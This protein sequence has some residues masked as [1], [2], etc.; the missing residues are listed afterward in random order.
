M[1]AVGTPAAERTPGGLGGVRHGPSP[2]LEVVAAAGEG[3][4]S[5]GFGCGARPMRVRYV[6]GAVEGRL[7][8]RAAGHRD[9]AGLTVVAGTALE[10]GQEEVAP[11]PPSV[12]GPTAPSGT[13]A[14]HLRFGHHDRWIGA[15]GG[16]GMVF[17]WPEASRTGSWLLPYPDVRLSVGPRNILHGFVGVGNSQ[18]SS[19]G[20]AFPYGGIGWHPSRHVRLEARFALELVHAESQY[21]GDLVGFV[22]VA[23]SWHVRLGAGAGHTTEQFGLVPPS[24][25]ANLGFLF[26]P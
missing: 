25:E 6:V 14:V 2:E 17:K 26:A 8:A 7:S 4:G 20:V 9:G 5:S 16:V 3:S 19:M 18:P 13:W 1:T 12:N 22:E 11:E 24:G 15:E 10:A 23:P 21:R